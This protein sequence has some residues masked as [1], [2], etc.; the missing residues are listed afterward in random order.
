MTNKLL[1]VVRS[2]YAPLCVVG[3]GRIWLSPGE[4]WAAGHKNPRS[5][6]PVF[7]VDL[8]D[9]SYTLLAHIVRTRIERGLYTAATQRA[10]RILEIAQH[11]PPWRLSM[12]RDEAE[13]LCVWFEKT[14]DIV[15][16]FGDRWPDAARVLDAVLRGW[17]AISV[18]IPFK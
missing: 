11:G 18:A 16:A 10:W 15:S 14:Y 5:E 4:E 1:R 17:R 6:R 13:T 2:S 3:L 8:D 9:D 12:E 7:T